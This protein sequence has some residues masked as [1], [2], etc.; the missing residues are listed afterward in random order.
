MGGI[1]L[2]LGGG[3]LVGHAWHLGVSAALADATGWDARRAAVVVGTS[4]GAVAGAEL[5][6]GFHPYDLLR[7]GVGAAPTDTPRPDIGP[8]SRRPACLSLAVRALAPW[9]LRPGLAA[10]GLLPRGRRDPAIIRDAVTGLSDRRWP[11]DPL[12]VCA[13]RLD[14]GRRV[15]FGRDAGVEVDV[16]TAVAASCAMA[17]FFTPV[18]VGGHDHVDGGA[19]SATNADVLAGAGLDLVVVSAP[20][21]LRPAAGAR[22]RRRRPPGPARAQ[23]LA[24][25]A[26]LRREL[27]ALRRQGTP[28]LVLE[29]GPDDLAVMG[30]IAASMDFDRRVAVAE[31]AR[32]GVRRRL[33]RPELAWE[34]SVLAAAAQRG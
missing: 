26:R 15:V 13:V 19:H 29:P 12:W 20:L 25:A 4:A 31:Q 33:E 27:Q 24:H 16:G 28:V 30:G 7:P 1:G 2:V 3:G 34:R 22:R 32:A 17:G 11:E 9:R 21:S 14:D 23:R 18:P 10:A 5:R 8:T 6:A